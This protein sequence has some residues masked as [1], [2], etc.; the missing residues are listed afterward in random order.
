M[1]SSTMICPQC[2]VEM[3]Q[4]AEKLLYEAGAGTAQVDPYL[5]GIVEQMHRCP[6]CGAGASI[7]HQEITDREFG[8]EA[9]A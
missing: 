6:G 2:G 3:N 5:G 8:P 1:G 4:H 7:V 9:K